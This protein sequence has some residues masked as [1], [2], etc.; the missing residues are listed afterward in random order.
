MRPVLSHSSAGAI[1]GI[2]ISWP[3]IASISSRTICDDLLVHAPAR[4]QKA[5]EP[6]ADLADQPRPDE[7]LVGD[8]LGV[9]RVV[10]EGRKE[11]L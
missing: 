6:G 2:N 7:Q 4:R 10:P 9:R 11:Q 1:T 3:P 5:P 8:G